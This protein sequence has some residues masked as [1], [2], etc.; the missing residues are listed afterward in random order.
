MNKT[1][2]Y[3]DKCFIIDRQY[4]RSFQMVANTELNTTN[5]QFES[6]IFWMKTQVDKFWEH[7]HPE[8]MVR[9]T[10]SVSTHVNEYFIFR[11]WK[12][13]NNLSGNFGPLLFLCQDISSRI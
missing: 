4:F 5:K 1:S 3:E 12:N 13:L 8:I 2:S 7:D 11:I 9:M 6:M 10:D